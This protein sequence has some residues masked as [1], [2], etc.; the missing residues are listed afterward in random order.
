M[1]SAFRA[2]YLHSFVKIYVTIEL[3]LYKKDAKNFFNEQR[4]RSEV[5]LFEEV[6]F[7]L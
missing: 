5:R 2:E 4:E 1:R 3:T 6:K 7:E